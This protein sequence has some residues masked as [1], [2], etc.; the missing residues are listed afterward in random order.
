MDLKYLAEL[1]KEAAPPPP[2]KSNSG[3][4]SNVSHNIPSDSEGDTSAGG[5]SI[6]KKPQNLTTY[7]PFAKNKSIQNMQVAMQELAKFVTVDQTSSATAVKHRSQVSQE[8]DPELQKNKKA[9]NDFIAE[10]YLGVVDKDIRGVEFSPNTSITKKEDK[11]SQQL[12]EIYELDVVMDTLKRIGAAKSEFKADGV[13]DFRTN[14]ALRNMVAFVYGILQAMND[15][16]VKSKF[17][18]LEQYNQFNNLVP[19]NDSY[20]KMP[21]DKKSK[22]AEKISEYL[23]KAGNLYEEFRGFI[24]NNATYRK[25]IQGNQE[26]EAIPKI[27]TPDQ[28]NA[29][30]DIEDASKTSY[31]KNSKV[32]GG[33]TYSNGKSNYNKERYVKLLENQHIMAIE[34]KQMTVNDFDSPSKSKMDLNQIPI[35]ALVNDTNFKNFAK[36]VG[37]QSDDKIKAFFN[38]VYNAIMKLEG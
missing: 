4:T 32:T 30:K 6:P 1:I 38:V 21:I 24:L 34:Q 8:G 33:I 7:A 31:D 12:D 9:F 19:K 22:N 35:S 14:N 27:L 11:K 18:N 20:E 37:Y 5:S 13:W 17:F 3:N 23:K 28:K 25:Y 16:G 15:F 26:H 2:R 29:V 10:N 36:S